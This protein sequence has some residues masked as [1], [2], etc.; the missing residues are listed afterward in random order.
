[1]TSHEAPVP[2][3]DVGGNFTTG[4]I[5][6]QGIVG[7]GNTQNQITY[8]N[9]TFIRPNGSTIEGKVWLYTEGYRPSTNSDNIFGRQQELKW[10]DEHFNQ[11]SALAITGIRGTGKSTLASMYIDVLENESKY[12]GIYWRRIDETTDISDVVGSF[13]TTIGKPIEEPG[14]LKIPDLLA[15]FFREL[16]AAPY[17]LVLD[18]FETILDAG[19]NVPLSSKPGFSELM[20]KAK[21]GFTRSRLMFTSWECPAS[22]R[23]LR[24]Q[25]YPIEGLDVQS[26]IR[27]L[28]KEGLNEEPE[29]EL[30]R[31]IELAGGH[32]LA[33]Q[34][35][36]Q[37]V[38]DGVETLSSMLDD[39][40]LWMGEQGEVAERI[41]NKVYNERLSDN[42]QKLLQYISLYRKPVPVEAIVAAAG[43]AHWDVSNV[44]RTA[45]GLIRKSRL[46]K[47]GGNYREESLIK[48][49]AYNKLDDKI[50]RH[51]LASQYY[52]S[53][54]IPEKCTKKE[55]VRSL[56]EAHHHAC[57]AKEYDQAFNIIFDN[58]LHE[59]LDRWGN[60]TTLI[61][62]YNRLL[63]ENPLN[64]EI[65]LS[66][67]NRHV[68]VLGN[69]GN[70]YSALGQ[71]KK[72]IKYYEQ[73]LEIIREIGDRRGEGN[74]L[75]NL[76]N[77][78]SHLGQVEKAIEHYEQALEIIR[79]IG[80]RRGEGAN[81]GNLGLAYSDLGYVEKAIEHYEYALDISREIDDK[82]NEGNWLGN[83]G[84]AY[85][86]LGEVEKAIEYHEQALDISIEIGNRR[87]EGNALGNLG[88]AYSDLEQVEKAIEY[89]KQALDISIEIGNRRGE[90]ANLGNLGIAYSDLEQM[91]KAIEYC[92]QALDI[93]IEIGDRRGERNHLGN[94]GSTYM[95]LGRFEKAIEYYKQALDISIEMGDRRNE[96]IHLGNLGIVY[97]DLGQ[98]KKAIE[99]FEQ[100][101][102]I[103]IE[104][105]DKRNEGSYLGNLGLAY[106]DLDQVKKA[107]EY[108][109]Q[110]L[111]I[112]IEIGDRR[113]EGIHLGNL[114]SAYIYLGQVEKAI[115]HYEQ[116]LDISR[117][118]ED[119]RGEGT[120]LGNLGSAYSALGQVEKAIEHYEQAL[121]IGKE[122]KDPGII[123]FFENNLS[124]I[125][126]SNQ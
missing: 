107:I 45:S 6:G 83:L 27:L 96:G 106:S 122:I 60:Y 67:K 104:I 112:S 70:V 82:H 58:N 31:A 124:L 46:I 111:D 53:L 28:R 19:T 29:S 36:V 76:G 39:N 34:L 98:I 115:E 59:D 66:T 77:V 79:E 14:R 121:V 37:L 117:E 3:I 103:A 30:E 94:L 61:D 88:S 1:M 23:G 54:P 25:C 55:D 72:A 92:K 90:G 21:E 80:D 100:A 47:T 62:L 52:L 32:P 41:L 10:I 68:A 101:L 123:M 64:D 2:K 40:T 71:V 119:R 56:I 73:A 69:L 81:L 5:S 12:A 57:M 7:D 118:I 18:N 109:K 99:H 89:Y 105:G 86:I 108:Y 78:Y 95:N 38:L 91:E 51:K 35:L 84:I 114:G 97:S 22:E 17:F 8:I 4:D 110:A 120:D 50:E 15:M 75:G 65:L 11:S 48:I 43:D 24:P 125:K 87:G 13:F 20:Q 9:S 33:L 26:A 126:H 63:P 113:N 44:K 102:E 85:R 74:I 93:S 42:E 16:D 49:Y 116:A